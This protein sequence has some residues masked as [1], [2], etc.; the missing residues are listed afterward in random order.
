LPPRPVF[1]PGGAPPGDAP[2][3][4]NR[5]E[6][7]GL[8]ETPLNFGP[9]GGLFGMLCEPASGDAD[10]VVVL[11]GAGR[12]PHYGIARSAVYMARQLAKA[13][14]ASLRIDFAGL[15]DSL[16]PPGREMMITDAFEV[17]VQDMKAAI[18]RLQALG[19]RRIAVQG[20]CS[21]AFHAFHA[22]LA[23][24]RVGMV[25]LINIPLFQEAY[26]AESKVALHASVPWH[27]YLDR[28]ARIHTWVRLLSGRGNLPS[29]LRGR[30]NRLRE[31]GRRLLQD[32]S[33]KPDPENFTRSAIVQLSQRGVKTVFLFGPDEVG[34][35]TVE[36]VF[37]PQGADMVKLDHVTLKVI[38]TFDHIMGIPAA[39]K[40]ATSAMLENLMSWRADPVI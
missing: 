10:I 4:A 27:Y 23:D 3:V 5:L 24:A 26:A 30:F 13:G 14:I 22:A 35:Y 6:R 16:A 36:D 8:V 37:G 12:T 18:D 31:A 7:T 11:C 9:N 21:G 28:L 34:Y 29:V 20:I 25:L 15:G 40:D 38:E 17:R 1:Q 39:Q 2:S 19:Y 32:H 33:I